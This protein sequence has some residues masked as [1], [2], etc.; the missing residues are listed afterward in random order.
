MNDELFQIPAELF[1][2][3]TKRNNSLRLTF[4]SQENISP[5]A[6]Q[7]LFALRNKLGNLFFGVRQINEQDVLSIPD[8]GPIESDD[9]RPSQRMRAVIFRIWEQ[10]NHGY[11]D[12]NLFYLYY[13]DKLIEMLKEKLA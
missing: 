9:K 6:T 1:K 8:T 3:E 4:D 5:D 13:M 12:F 2:V 10:N 7:R 11:D